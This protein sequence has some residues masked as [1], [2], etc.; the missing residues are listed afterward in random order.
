MCD[1][2]SRVAW[3]NDGDA[4]CDPLPASGAHPSRYVLL[5]APVSEGNAGQAYE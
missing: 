5:G 3:L 4:Q 1:I 2:H